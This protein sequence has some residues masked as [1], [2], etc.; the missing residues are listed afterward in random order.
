[1]AYN[2][3]GL[4]QWDNLSYSLQEKIK[5]LENQVNETT[6]RIAIHKKNIDSMS[7]LYSTMISKQTEIS[8]KMNREYN[9][10]DSKIDYYLKSTGGAGKHTKYFIE[11]AKYG[12]TARTNSEFNEE[13]LDPRPMLIYCFAFT[14]EEEKTEMI[15]NEDLRNI[16]YEY[17]CEY[18][19]YD[20]S[21]GDRYVPGE[22]NVWTI[23]GDTEYWLPNC[24]FLIN[25]ITHKLYYYFFVGEYTDM[26]G[27]CDENTGRIYEVEEV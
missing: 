20:L 21:T 18:A 4:V 7:E 14:T 23:G 16:S 15:E 6:K 5:L 11:N 12:E 2:R 10:L 25:P 13:Q 24:M 22:D 3:N 1:M 26:S 19:L 9:I 8:H 17:D 27:I